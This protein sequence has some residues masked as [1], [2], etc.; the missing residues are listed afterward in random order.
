MV[1]VRNSRVIYLT[2]HSFVVSIPVRVPSIENTEPTVFVLT[3]VVRMNTALKRVFH[4]PGL[5]IHAWSTPGG[6]KRN[7][8]HWDGVPAQLPD[9]IS[10]RVRRFSDI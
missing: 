9:M 6:Q 10:I 1:I 3:N 5:S 7:S 8:K 2:R 4:L